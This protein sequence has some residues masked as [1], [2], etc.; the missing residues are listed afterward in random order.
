M[1]TTSSNSKPVRQVS[2]PRK[3]LEGPGGQ[4]AVTNCSSASPWT[5]PSMVGGPEKHPNCNNSHIQGSLSVVTSSSSS[6]SW[7]L[8]VH[9]RYANS[10]AP[11]IP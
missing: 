5:M 4:M 3:S 11:P 9:V 6:I 2:T 10:Q 8:T 1:V 7:E